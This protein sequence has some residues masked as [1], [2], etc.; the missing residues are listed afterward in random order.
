MHAVL[1]AELQFQWRGSEAKGNFLVAC[2]FACDKH[3]VTS[4][5]CRAMGR[6]TA[7][8]EPFGFPKQLKSLYNVDRDLLLLENRMRPLPLREEN[9]ALE[10]S[11]A[12]VRLRC[13]AEKV[14]AFESGWGSELQFRNNAVCSCRVCLSFM[15]TCNLR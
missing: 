8:S 12:C 5:G 13:D 6:R 11:F 4:L 10:K 9:C 2:P 15:V 7:S 3:P 14:K 1:R